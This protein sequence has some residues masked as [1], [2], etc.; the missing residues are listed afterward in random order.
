MI[1]IVGAMQVEIEGLVQK[2]KKP[3][4]KIIG[5][6][7]FVSG[8]IGASKVVVVKCGIGKV[9]SATATSVMLMAFKDIK[10]VI[11]LGVAGGLDNSLFQGDFVV[12]SSCIQHDFDLTVEGLKMGQ[13]AGCESR[14]FLCCNVA[15]SKMQMVLDGLDFRYKIGTIVSGDQF[16][17][18]D[19]KTAWLRSEFEALACD[20]E[21]ASIAQ[22]C[23]SFN[24]PFISVRSISDGATD[25]A[26][27][28]FAQFA[29]IASERSISAVEKFLLNNNSKI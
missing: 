27:L 23:S 18:C 22:V 25:D 11:N 1:G 21:S 15:I 17:A 28:D 3:K 20:M 8:V 29:V 12:G 6:L 14:E 7:S 10:L 2:I 24:M 5:A 13:L 26:F 16:I 9:N 19:Q 4:I